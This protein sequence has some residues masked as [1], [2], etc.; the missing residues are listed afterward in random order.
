MIGHR[1]IA[2]GDENSLLALEA[3]SFKRSVTQVRRQSG[4][5]RLVARELLA[6]FGILEAELPRSRSGAPVWPAGIVGSLS[7]DGE[8]AVA[9]VARAQIYAGIGIDVEPS[10]PLPPELVEMVA[11]P[12]ERRRYSPECVNSRVLF[13]AKEAIYKAQYPLDQAFLEFHD[14]E[15]DL[16]LNQGLTRGGRHVA[17]AFT[18]VPR[19]IALAFIA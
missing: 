10:L 6:G 9:A 1:T 16:E 3:G 12:A 17:I 14:I 13:A 18:T 11:T 8:I 2:A 7:H 15:V 4:A 19:T 5:A